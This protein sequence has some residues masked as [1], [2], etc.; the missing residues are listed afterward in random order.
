MSE[1]TIKSYRHYTGYFANFIGKGLKCKDIT[2]KTV[3]D[4][5]LHMKNEKVQ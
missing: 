1:Y 2:L 3:E 5:I 4:Y